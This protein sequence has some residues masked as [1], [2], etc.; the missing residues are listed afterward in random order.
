MFHYNTTMLRCEALALSAHPEFQ[1]IS[2]SGIQK[3]FVDPAVNTNNS[4][5][6]LL[7]NYKLSDKTQ[8]ALHLSAPST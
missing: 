4:H 1:Y 7:L 5:F 3:P 6:Q 2:K 8:T